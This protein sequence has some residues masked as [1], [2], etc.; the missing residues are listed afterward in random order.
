MLSEFAIFSAT[1][2]SSRITE[3][4]CSV[5]NCLFSLFFATLCSSSVTESSSSVVN[6][7]FSFFLSHL[8]SWLEVLHFS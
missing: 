5:V 1:L 4:S 2:C 7:L 8:Y 6:C 3:S